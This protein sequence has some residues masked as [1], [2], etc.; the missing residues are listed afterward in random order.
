MTAGAADRGQ[1]SARRPLA[2]ARR[3]RALLAGGDA[4]RS[5]DPAPDPPRRTGRRTSAPRPGADPHARR[6]HRPP[7]VRPGATHVH[8]R[9]PHG[10]GAVRRRLAGDAPRPRP[11]GHRRPGRRRRPPRSRC[12][13]RAGRPV[14][15]AD[16]RRRA[17]RASSAGRGACTPIR[18]VTTPRVRGGDPRSLLAVIVAGVPA[19]RPRAARSTARSGRSFRSSIQTLVYAGLIRL[20]VVDTGALRGR[21]WASAGRIGRAL[22]ELASGALWALP[23]IVA[24]VAGLRHPAH[25]L[26]GHAGQPAAARPASRRA[27]LLHLAGRGHRRADRRGAAVP[28]LRDDGLG[29]GARRR[30]ALV[31]AALFFAAGPR[32]RPSTGSRAARRSGWSSSGSPRGCPSRSPSAGCSSA[33]GSIW[34]PLGLHVAFNGILLVIGGAGVGGR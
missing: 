6:R 23:V 14:R 17:R 4:A 16:R 18:A 19:G 34:A 11:D 20:L 25:G 9:G 28:G 5:V 33:R 12:S 21:R 3:D 2:A 30:R 10:A 1:A 24:T 26:P 13:R 22:T 32:P 29:P 27:S 7:P 15:R 31:R 8:H